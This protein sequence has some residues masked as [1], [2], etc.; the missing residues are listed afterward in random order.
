MQ[1]VQVDHFEK[2]MRMIGHQ[3]PGIDIR[4]RFQ[5]N[6]PHSGYEYFPIFIVGNDLSF[7]DPPDNHMMQRAGRNESWT[8]RHASACW[9]VL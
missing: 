1:K 4:S 7:F 5:G 9:F 3:R 8:S 6:R 2:D